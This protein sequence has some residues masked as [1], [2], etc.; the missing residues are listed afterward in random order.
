[1][2][3]PLA[4]AGRIHSHVTRDAAVACHTGLSIYLA[5]F[6]P[7]GPSRWPA[8]PTK[9]DNVQK[10][11]QIGCTCILHPSTIFLDSILYRSSSSISVPNLVPLAQRFPEPEDPLSK[12]FSASGACAVHPLETE[13][14]KDRGSRQGS[15]DLQTGHPG[16]QPFDL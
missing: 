11:V 13:T 12:R 10:G 1:M 16:R 8:A 9:Y 4:R 15:R 5:S 6:R 2:S 3:P 14:T 7:I